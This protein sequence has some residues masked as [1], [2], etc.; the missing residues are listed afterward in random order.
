MLK[1]RMKILLLITSV[2]VLTTE[3]TA[4]EKKEFT[5]EKIFKDPAF[6]TETVVGINWMNNG[7]YYSSQ[8]LDPQSDIQYILKYDITTGNV[9][10]TIVNG[11]TLVPEGENEPIQF[12][13]Y[14]LSKSEAKILF[15][16]QKEKIYR[17]S[18]KAFYYV[19]DINSQNLVKLTDGDK[20]S[21]ATFSPDG[22]KV[23]FVR[24]NN[25][26]YVTLSDMAEHEITDNG[27][28]NELING[29]TDWVYEEEFAFAKAFY[30]SPDGN[31]I[32]FYTFDESEV[33]EYNMQEWGNLYPQDYK[34]KY[35]KAGEKNSEV[36]VSVYHLNNKKTVNMDVGENKDIYL[37]RVYWTS[38]ADLLSI[39]RLNRLQNK[40]EILHANPQT[41]NTD[42]V[43]TEESAT[44][45][46]INYTDDLTYL[47][48][49]KGFIRTSEKDG[50]KHIYLHEM[51]GSQVRQITSGNWEV[52]QFYGIDEKKDLIYYRSTEDSPLERHLYTINVNGKKKNKLTM[53]KGTHRINL[54][55]DFKYYIDYYSS[56]DT[57]TIVSL[58]KA[59]SGKE[60]KVLENNEEL[61]EK[62]SQY[63]LG[64][65]EFFTFETNAG[66][67]LN[68]YM[69]KPL[70]FDP[71]K[72]Y[73]V[74]MYVYGGPGS[75]TVLNTWGGS[76][77]L[78][79]HYLTQKDFIIV[80]IDNRGTGAR[81][82]D[83]KHITYAN[84]GKYEVQ[85]QIA[86]AKYLGDLPYVDASRIGIWGWSYGGY[87]SSL[88]M[89]MGEGI[90]EAA[91]AV[92]PVTNWRFYD[93]IYTERYLKT[94]Q[95]NPDGY[96]DF[97]PVTHADKLEGAFLLIH[98]T[99]DDNVHFQNAVALQNALIAEDKQFQ[100]FYYP[101]RNHGISGGNTTYHLFKMMTIF[102]EKELS[103]GNGRKI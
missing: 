27:K 12:N 51:D 42:V 67:T 101:N 24:N 10:D 16:I 40:L 26:Y 103:A 87:M 22:S 50:Y 33:N 45:V 98:G 23:A 20:Q 25:L 84:L 81:G 89:F 18:S 75:Q 68:G 58:H 61:R 44:Y 7:Q 59:S 74:L 91:I 36:S 15:S 28:K 79:F 78:W 53:A 35:P 17:R 93:T 49:N 57:P 52:S 1:T 8:T 30:W 54:S 39:V 71:S 6:S 80:S 31:S 100:S 56:I 66:V 13:D 55:P 90:F 76:R 102:L 62:I 38:N 60:I 14:A 77:E 4:Q 9:I 85:D 97:S 5:L 47:K 95:L 63:A 32:A 37:P 48:D 11:S 64:N 21:Y 69:I 96:D 2:L 94:P 19:Y 99:G 3:L 92:A 70:D 82:R 83:F 41:G 86:G 29:S 34:F 43:L 72:K 46:D 65:K 88:A 73:P